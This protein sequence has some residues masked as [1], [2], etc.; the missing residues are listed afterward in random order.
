MTLF[1]SRLL[2][3][4]LRAIEGESPTLST[5]ITENNGSGFETLLLDRAKLHDKKLQISIRFTH[6]KKIT[7]NL[8]TLLAL[9]LFMLGTLGVKTILFSEQS[10]EI[11]FFWAFSLFFVPNVFMLLVWL[12]VF[13][14]EN[15]VQNSSLARF[16]LAIIKQFEHRFNSGLTEQK[17]Y[18]L[19]FHC[20][21]D[22][23]FSKPLGRYQLSKLTHLLWL[24]YFI[25]ATLMSVVMLATHQVDF[26]WQT[27]ILSSDSFQTLTQL[28]AYLPQKLGFPVPSM[29]QIQQSHLGVESIMD[30]ENRRLAWSSLLISS[31]F[32]YGLLPRLLLFLLLSKQLKRKMQRYRLD[33]SSLYYV[34]LRQLLKPNKTTLGIIDADATSE[35][36]KKE[37]HLPDPAHKVTALPENYYP[38]AI[39][40]SSRQFSLAEKHLQQ[41]NIDA[42][43]SLINVC[44]YQRQQQLLAGL[45]NSQSRTVCLYVSLERL[46]DRGL[47]RFIS[48]LTSL[49][50]KQFQLLLLIEK[51]QSKQRDSDWYQLASEVGIK[52]DNILHIEV[53]ES[54]N[55]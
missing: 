8:Y 27:S 34:Q 43:L 39:E 21:F 1:E 40:L 13:F 14:K 48:Q 16:S 9:L 3:E 47:K 51:Q 33:L 25:G 44:D 23:H 20:Y 22:L 46:P 15:L 2:A 37:S 18:G 10:T 7:K 52:L 35:G 12:F 38:I 30:A 26:I 50:N 32:L 31:L 4:G 55:E 36:I 6:F 53:K 17:N 45:K 42:G 54:K 49:P 24:S 5:C 28:L 41:Y 11:N 29:L 19:L